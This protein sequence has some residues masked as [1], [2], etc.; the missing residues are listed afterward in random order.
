MCALVTVVQTCALPF[1]RSRSY[2]TAFNVDEVSQPSFAKFNAFLN[3]TSS[4]GN[5]SGSLFV[6]NITNKATV[7]S[8]YVSSG[9]FGFPLN[10]YLEIG[11]A[12]R[13]DR[14]CQYVSIWV[15]AV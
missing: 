9:L 13:G 10:G 8:A 12:T 1:Y 3:W 2:L 4:D 11:R 6:R 7:S 14:V 5:V 15:V